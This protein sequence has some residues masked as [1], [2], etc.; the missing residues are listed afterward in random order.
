MAGP[1]RLALAGPQDGDLLTGGVGAGLAAYGS[2]QRSG[3]RGCK[4]HTLHVSWLIQFVES[5]HFCDDGPGMNGKLQFFCS[6]R[7]VLF[8]AIAT[9]VVPDQI[10]PGAVGFFKTRMGKFLSCLMKGMGFNF[11]IVCCNPSS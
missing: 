11:F 4:D 9:G 7:S 3:Q 6:S 1:H 8:W 5:I 10:V 2:S